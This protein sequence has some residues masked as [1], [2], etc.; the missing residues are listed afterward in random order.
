MIGERRGL[1][2][3]LAG[4]ALVEEVQDLGHVELDVLEVEVLLVIL[5]HLE[6]V[7]E[8]EIEFEEPSVAT[9]GVKSV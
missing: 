8:L 5:L 4:E 1:P 9:C 3:F 6:Q 2:A 7:V